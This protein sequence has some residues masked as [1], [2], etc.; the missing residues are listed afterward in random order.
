MFENSFSTQ[1]LYSIFYK[2]WA[3]FTPNFGGKPF[4]SET[5]HIRSYKTLVFVFML[6]GL[7]LWITYK[8]FLYTELST[9]HIKNPF[10][11]L[12]TL[13]K[14]GYMWVLK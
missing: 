11:D 10:N 7:V 8:S 6:D 5:D 3:S 12:N 9:P 13:S 14:S 2:V 4:Q 1:V